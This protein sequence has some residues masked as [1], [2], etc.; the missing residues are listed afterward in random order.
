M[1]N[2]NGTAYFEARQEIAQDIRRRVLEHQ[3]NVAHMKRLNSRLLAGAGLQR[4]NLIAVGD[5]WFD[6]PFPVPQFEQ[7]D[8]VAHLQRL[9]SRA[10]LILSLAHHGNAI[11]DM[12]G[13]K[14]LDEFTTQLQDQRNGQFDAILFSGGGND[15]VGNQ[16]RLWLNDCAACGGNAAQGLNQTRV[17]AVLAVVMAGYEDLI[18]VRNKVA[19]NLPIFVHSYDLAIPNNTSAPCA[20]PWLHPSLVDRGWTSIAQGQQIVATLL[21][22]FAQRLNSLAVTTSSFFHI[23]TQRTLQASQWANELHPTPEGFAAITAKFV[24]ALQGKFGMRIR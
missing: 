8:I 5:S 13:T 15:L 11:E 3:A 24:A 2:R 1:R 22:Q 19:P 21:E 4:L 7:S 9:P 6:Y 12:L 20:G 23:Q 18:A 16:F 14:K 10:P 17:N